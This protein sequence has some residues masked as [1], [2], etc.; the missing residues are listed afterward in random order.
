[1]KKWAYLA[2]YIATV[3]AANWM[4]GNFGT[5]CV[6]DGP[7]MIPVGFGMTAPSGV[8]M[9]G[10]ALI[11]R[12]QVQEH[13]GTRWSLGGIIFGAILSYL[14][15]DPF[16]AVASIVAFGISELGDFAVYTHVRKH[17]RALAVAVSGLVGSVMD[18]IA[19]LFI[20]FGSLAYVEGQIFGKL[21][22]SLL[23]AAAIKW[24]RNES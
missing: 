17:G 24:M 10:A 8:L 14:L 21:I 2:G 11:L 22:I 1:M 23:A 7:C 19:F 20:A 18:S 9:V 15:A 16:I 12:D 6:P 5:F 4:I 3:P 13:L